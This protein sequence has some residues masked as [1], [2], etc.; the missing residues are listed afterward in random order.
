MQ[1]HRSP[2]VSSE[3]NPNGLQFY[4]SAMISPA[5]ALAHAAYLPILP[6]SFMR[7]FYVVSYVFLFGDLSHFVIIHLLM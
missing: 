2:P 6:D 4:I 5:L 3:V 7:C 1:R